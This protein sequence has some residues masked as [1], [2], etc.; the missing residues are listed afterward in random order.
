MGEKHLVVGNSK[1][2][3]CEKYAR[4][5]FMLKKNDDLAF[6]YACNLTLSLKSGFLYFFPL[7][8]VAH[9][10]IGCICSDI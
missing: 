4:I 8:L 10:G 6:L 5:N 2:N 1:M 7:V 9:I 3:V